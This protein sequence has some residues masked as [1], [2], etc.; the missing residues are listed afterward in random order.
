MSERKPASPG[1]PSK[2]VLSQP[3]A[4]PLPSKPC[5]LG[6]CCVPDTAFEPGHPRRLEDTSAQFSRHIHPLGWRQT[7]NALTVISLGLRDSKRIKGVM[8]QRQAVDGF[9]VR[10]GSQ[11]RLLPAMMFK[12]IRDAA[13]W[14]SWP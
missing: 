6:T 9:P 4:Q 14:L 10:R 8:R 3:P 1:T 5:A 13:A 7:I 12:G 2:D 11:G